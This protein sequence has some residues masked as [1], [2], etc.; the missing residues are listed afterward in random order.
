MYFDFVHPL[1][2]ITSMAQ[3]LDRDSVKIPEQLVTLYK[4]TDPRWTK[5]ADV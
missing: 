4:W 3:V 5:V 2:G 1:L